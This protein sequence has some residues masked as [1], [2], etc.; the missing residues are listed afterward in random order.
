MLPGVEDDVDEV[1][2][3]DGNKDKDDEGDVIMSF[4]SMPPMNI[5]L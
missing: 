4:G 5:L 1:V 2:I 3:D